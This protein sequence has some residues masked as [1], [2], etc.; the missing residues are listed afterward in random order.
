MQKVINKDLLCH[1]FVI[2]YAYIILEAFS[3]LRISDCV[4]ARWSHTKPRSPVRQARTAL[5]W[6]KACQSIWPVNWQGNIKPSNSRV[7]RLDFR[8]TLMRGIDKALPIQK[9]TKDRV[10]WAYDKSDLLRI[11]NELPMP[12]SNQTAISKSRHVPGNNVQTYECMDL[13][14]AKLII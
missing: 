7:Y 10:R 4:D 6:T 9:T 12:M 11:G 1:F 13:D 2:V 14:K 3:H 8:I 5:I